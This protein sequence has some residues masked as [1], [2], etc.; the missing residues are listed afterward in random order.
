MLPGYWSIFALLS[1]DDVNPSN[2]GA[3]LSWIRRNIVAAV[4]GALADAHGANH[5]PPPIDDDLRNALVRLDDDAQTGQP[6]ARDA[7]RALALLA[8]FFD[9]ES[10][11]LRVAN[12]GA[13]RAFLGRRVS[14]ANYECTE[15][16][17]PGAPRYLEPARTRR[18]DVEELVNKGVFLSRG[19]L[20]ASSVETRG[21]EVRDGDFLV[22]GSEGAW[23]SMEG[24]EAVRL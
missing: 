3:V 5:H 20:D 7:G 21:V 16:V 19:P 6:S 17:G 13:G 18:V 9:S 22:L 10:R 12:T 11:V 14:G 4:A 1:A 23:D 24:T 8:F 2:H 15:L